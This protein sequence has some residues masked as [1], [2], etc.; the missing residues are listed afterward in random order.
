MASVRLE[1]SEVEKT[2]LS[3]FEESVSC[4]KL[5]LL[6]YSVLSQIS[7]TVYTVAAIILTMTTAQSAQCV[8]QK[9]PNLSNG[10]SMHA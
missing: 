9:M 7:S 10:L 4:E 2:S 5:Q 6:H 3:E 8:C 1:L